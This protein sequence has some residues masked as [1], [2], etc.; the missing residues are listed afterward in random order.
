MADSL[1]SA[2]QVWVILDNDLDY[3]V[4]GRVDECFRSIRTALG[5]GA[6][7]ILLP[8]G[9]NDLCEFFEDHDL[10]TLRLL[11]ERRP[12]PGD[13]RFK[14]LKLNVA[15]PAPRWIVENLFCKGDVHI[16]I[17]EPNI[18]KSW[19]TMAL[20][21][22]L[23]NGDSEFLGHHIVGGPHRVLYV[24][25]ENPEDLV[26]DR[27]TRLG[28]RSDAVDNI[29]YIHNGSVRLDRDP[30]A[31]LDEAIEF[32]PTLIVLD[33]LT[34]L[35]G[36]DENAAGSM[37]ALFNDAI[38]PLARN[39]GAGV[40]VIHHVSKTDSTSS[41]KRSRGSGDI[42][43][44][45]DTG[46]DVYKGDDETLRLKNF[47]ARRAAQQQTMYVFIRDTDDGKVTVTSMPGFGNVF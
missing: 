14:L 46:Y 30:D 3:R 15:P 33:S 38:N 47:K 24:D 23:A 26:I 12:K 8:R 37:S 1:R 36:E 22:A 4:A 2:E 19:I 42:T 32:E 5:A 43:A 44:S 10:D 39:A 9:I 25:E 7:R 18:G 11:V 20:A 13:S 40:I 29:R 21:V 31:L 28:L 6:R 41:F 16:I 17:G 34:R 45:P 27:L 35:H